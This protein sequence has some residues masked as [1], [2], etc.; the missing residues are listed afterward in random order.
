MNK[1][2]KQDFLWTQTSIS[3]FSSRQLEQKY[4]VREV[5]KVKVDFSHLSQLA[6]L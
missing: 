4:E 3:E 2:K 6:L 5:S 1:T